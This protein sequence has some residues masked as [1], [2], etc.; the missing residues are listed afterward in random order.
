MSE[1]LDA[2]IFKQNAQSKRGSGASRSSGDSGYRSRSPAAHASSSTEKKFL[3]AIS[4]RFKPKRTG[5]TPN[6]LVNPNKSGSGSVLPA[7]QALL[8]KPD[9]GD[10]A[11]AP[12]SPQE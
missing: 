9:G 6:H 7:V 4:S 5:K 10:E 1:G 11:I 12:T 8:F 3:S 2:S